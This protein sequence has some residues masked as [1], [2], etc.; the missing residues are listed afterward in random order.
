[1]FQYEDLGVSFDFYLQEENFKESNRRE[2]GEGMH[3]CKTIQNNA[4]ESNQKVIYWDI[5]SN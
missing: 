1:V 4:V 2:S 5:S 3:A